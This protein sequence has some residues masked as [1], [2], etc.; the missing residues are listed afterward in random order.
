MAISTCVTGALVGP[1]LAVPMVGTLG[2]ESG[3]LRTKTTV[4][5]AAGERASA[6]PT[7]PSAV[8]LAAIAPSLKKKA[9]RGG[10]IEAR[11]HPTRN[12]EK[13]GWEHLIARQINAGFKTGQCHPPP[14]FRSSMARTLL[15]LNGRP[16]SLT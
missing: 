11:P 15:G 13:R 9:P 10:G 2:P 8:L 16:R 5:S 1:N 14:H 12:Q 7:E 6:H 3:V 4:R